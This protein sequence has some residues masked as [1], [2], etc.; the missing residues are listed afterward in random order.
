MMLTL[1]TTEL[2]FMHTFIN[3]VP[4]SALALKEAWIPNT[5]GVIET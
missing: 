3:K 5:I 4:L 2:P 1:G